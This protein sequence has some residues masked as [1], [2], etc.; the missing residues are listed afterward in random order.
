MI[1]IIS[2][3][4]FNLM[5]GKTLVVPI[6][7]LVVGAVGLMVFAFVMKRR[8]IEFD[9]TTPGLYGVTGRFGSGKSYFLT[10]MASICLKRGRLVF[11]TY[12]IAGY[13]SFDEWK[14]GFDAGEL[15]IGP[16]LVEPSQVP[17]DGKGWAQIL[18]MPNGSTLLIDEA[19]GWWPSE[20]WKAPVDVRMWL[21][22]I[23]HRDITVWWGTQRVEAV[24]KWLRDLSFGIW[25]CEFFKAGHRYTLYDPRVI[26][27][28]K[29]SRSFDARIVLRRS[30]AVMDMYDTK[31][32]SRHS[33]EWGGSD[34]P[35]VAPVVSGSSA[36]GSF[37]SPF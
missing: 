6:V 24:A 29:G 28:K 35:A 4:H 11:A 36:G 31:N 12:E 30:Q 37:R 5:S 32:Q 33:V 9:A 16:V 23:R 7:A 18:A 3:N 26:G 21:S 8:S 25:E 17:G 2:I 14:S 10:W 34:L 22:T 20:A 1:G 15:W 27:G 19:H 13:R